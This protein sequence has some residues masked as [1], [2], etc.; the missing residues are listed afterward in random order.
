[1]RVRGLF[2]PAE[3]AKAAELVQ[4]G[5]EAWQGDLLQPESLMGIACDVTRTYHLAGLHS[6]SVQKMRDLYVEGT[7]NLLQACISGERGQLPRTGVSSMH[8][9][10]EAFVVASN[11]SVYGECGE[12]WVTEEREPTTHHPFGQLT[13]QME[14]LV[15]EACKQQNFPGILL[16]IADVY[17]PEETHRLVKMGETGAF[18]L[19]GD[20][21][22]WSSHV[23]IMD[24][25][26][27]LLLSPLLHSGEIYNVCDDLPVRRRDLYERLS[28][29]FGAA[30]P[31]WLPLHTVSEKMKLSIHGLR[32][33][34]VRLSN[35][36]IKQALH[37][38]LQYPT[39]LD[40][41]LALRESLRNA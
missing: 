14:R 35:H 19:V 1:M 15:L 33:F 7:R 26:Q 36:K 21:T 10:L 16:R 22:S 6:L 17:G 38:S 28:L 40:G 41:C 37:L 23:Q 39:Y 3:A 5:M 13:L 2:L 4:A 9:S 11:L 34:S 29:E 25:I 8:G 27:I 18:H 32:A 20:G 30:C 12:E 31:T 24:L